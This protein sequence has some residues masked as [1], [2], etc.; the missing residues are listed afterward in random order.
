MMAVKIA[1]IQ[2]NSTDNIADNVKVIDCMITDAAALGAKFIALPE[3]AF[4]MAVG[5]NFHEQVSA[6]DSNVA[7][8]A[9][10][11]WSAKFGI[12]LLAGSIAVKNIESHTSISDGSDGVSGGAKYLNRCLLFNPEGSV[13]ARYDKIHLF[14]VSIP[15]GESHKESNRFI[16]GDKAVVADIGWCKVGMSICYDVRF[17]YL[18][19]SLAL[20][21]ADI[22]T[23]PAAFTHFTGNKGG[24]HVLT[25]ARAM[26]TGCFIIA[27]A[28]CGHHAGGR[29]TYGHSLIINPWGEIIA[30]AGEKPGIITA[31][32]DIKEVSN[33]RAVMPSL[34]HGRQNDFTVEI[35]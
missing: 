8:I 25:R 32:I 12:W 24:W 1:V 16:A 18:Y 20:A 33:T 35:I 29:K 17:P 15:G 7:V 2:T 6:E 31:D 13:Q 30:Q 4:L 22:I 28:Q 34:Q 14:D 10:R 23:I 11:N 26:E 19:R 27:P 5:K 3:N 9:C 21:G